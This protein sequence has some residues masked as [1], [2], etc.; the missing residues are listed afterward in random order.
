MYVYRQQLPSYV[1]SHVATYVM[2][3]M[4]IRRTLNDKIS[5]I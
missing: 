4:S 2:V 5:A 3:S 1:A